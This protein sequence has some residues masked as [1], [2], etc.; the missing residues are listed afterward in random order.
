MLSNRC[1]NV[2]IE[3]IEFY[4]NFKKYIRLFKQ[5][6]LNISIGILYTL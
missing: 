2:C 5:Q 6:Y 3:F 1:V 4:F